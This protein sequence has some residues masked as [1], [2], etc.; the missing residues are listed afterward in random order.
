MIVDNDSDQFVDDNEERAIYTNE[1]ITTRV[2][3]STGD[4]GE[5][6]NKREN[7]SIAENTTSIKVDDRKLHCSQLKSINYVALYICTYYE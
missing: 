6:D 1:N 2:E 5:R 3:Q 4:D 7:V